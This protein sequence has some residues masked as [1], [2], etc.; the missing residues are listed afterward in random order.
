MILG[1]PP[2]S[3]PQRT[4]ATA[5]RFKKCVQ[6]R[7]ELGR[8]SRSHGT[9]SGRRSRDARGHV[10]D[11]GEPNERSWS[12]ATRDQFV[13]SVR[14]MQVRRTACV[15]VRAGPAAEGRYEVRLFFHRSVTATKYR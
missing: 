14:T 11:E 13:G 4:P 7:A 3:P 1:T 12:R 9:W 6:S 5:A 15:A 8:R 10:M 2:A